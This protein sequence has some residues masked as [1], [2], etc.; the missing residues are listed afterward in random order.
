MIRTETW[1]YGFVIKFPWWLPPLIALAIIAG[2]VVLWLND[3]AR[4]RATHKRV[5]GPGLMSA[6]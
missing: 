6:A 4:M 5:P 3:R 2:V 1:S